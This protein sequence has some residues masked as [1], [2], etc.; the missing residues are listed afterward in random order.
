M[1]KTNLFGRFDVVSDDSDHQFLRSNNGHCFSNS[2]SEVYK[3]IMREWKTLEQN[4][5]ES[6][7]V[8]VYERRIDLMRAVIVGAAGTPYHDGLFFFD[9]AFPSDYPKHPPLLH[10]HSFGLRVNSNLYTN[11]RVCL[12]LL[13][14]WIGNKREKWD[15]CE[16]TLLQVLLS[17][18]GLV[19]NEKPF[20]NEPGYERERF[21]VLQSKS[22]AYNDLVFAL[23]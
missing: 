4:L 17:I 6:I 7:Y 3:A 23:T 12:S 13:N 5:P 21:V 19:L 22:R 20:F 10:F 14:T 16:S 9:I 11:G 1:E 15:P 8:R 18:Q 2:K